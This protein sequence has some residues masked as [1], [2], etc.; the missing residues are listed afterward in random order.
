MEYELCPMC[1]GNGVRPIKDLEGKIVGTMWCH[2]CA[3]R[4]EIPKWG[5][6]NANDDK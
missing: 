5:T 3:G 2:N 1:D 4:G 6:K